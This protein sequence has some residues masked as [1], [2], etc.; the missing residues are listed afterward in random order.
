MSQ[1]TESGS[2][3]LARTVQRL[4]EDKSWLS[5]RNSILAVLAGLVI[6]LLSLYSPWVGLG[7]VVALAFVL[8]ALTKPVILGYAMIIATVIASGMPRDRIVPLLRPNEAAMVIVFVLSLPIILFSPR[9][10]SRRL[11]TLDLGMALFLLGMVLL[12]AAFYLLRG[13]TLLLQDVMALAAPAQYV[14]L[15]VVFQ[16]I[17]TSEKDRQR[18]VY[19]MLIGGAVVAAIGL[20]QAAR[21]PFIEGFLQTWYPSSHLDQAR[22]YGRVTSI[23]PGWNVFGILMMINL[24]IV[25]SLYISGVKLSRPGRLIVWIAAGLCGAGLLASGSF[26]GIIGLGIGILIIGRFDRQNFQ[27][28]LLLGILLALAAFV[29]RSFIAEQIDFQFGQGNSLIPQTLQ[30]RF[31][32]W[33]STFIPAVR[34]HGIWRLSPDFSDVFQWDYAESQYLYLLLRS[35]MVSLVGHLLWAGITIAWLYR[36]VRENFGISR[37][38]IVSALAVLVALTIAGITNEVFSFSGAVD[39]LWILLGIAASTERVA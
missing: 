8:A 19:L 37:S 35:G 14:L 28:V 22:E 17:P 9:H 5:T 30:Y 11:R 23:V 21:L 12:P 13:E 38:V 16:Y 36:R 2:T 25:R 27:R 18:L 6:G 10:V 31:E 7:V 3:P 1:S 34:E 32:L 15:Y 26:A 20:M 4:A 33:E 39:Y 24:L 29:L